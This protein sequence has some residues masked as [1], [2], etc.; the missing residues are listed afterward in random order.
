MTDLDQLVDSEPNDALLRTALMERAALCA[1]MQK[2]DESLRDLAMILPGG[3]GA[4]NLQ[5]RATDAFEAFELRAKVAPTLPSL[6]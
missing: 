3:K 6:M 2:F 5:I 4:P 1:K